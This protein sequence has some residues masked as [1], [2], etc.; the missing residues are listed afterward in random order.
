V[1]ATTFYDNPEKLAKVSEG[2]KDA[3]EGLDIADIPEKE[4]F[5]NRGW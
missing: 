3:M 2:L 4:M 1:Q 5:Q